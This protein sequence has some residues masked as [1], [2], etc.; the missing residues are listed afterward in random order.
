MLIAL[1]LGGGD[2]LLC[3]VLVLIGWLPGLI[4]DAI[5]I[6]CFSISVAKGQGA[7]DDDNDL[8]R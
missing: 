7:E 6:A 2:F 1:L 4:T 5:A 8:T 3:G